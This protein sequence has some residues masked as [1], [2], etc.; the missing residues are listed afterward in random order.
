M[1]GLYK[2]YKAERK[3]KY[4]AFK[5]YVRSPLVTPLLDSSAQHAGLH[6]GWGWAYLDLQKSISTQDSGPKP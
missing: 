5:A 3:L 2:A 4:Q 6:Q 1:E